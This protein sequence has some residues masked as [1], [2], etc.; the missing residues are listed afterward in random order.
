MRLFTFLVISGLLAAIGV[1][2]RPIARGMPLVDRAAIGAGSFSAIS[3]DDS[4]P[5][6]TGTA[7][8]ALPSATDTI[9]DSNPS[10]NSSLT[11][12]SFPSPTDDIPSFSIFT[13]DPSTIVPSVTDSSV[14][15]SATIPP[16]DTVSATDP[17]ITDPTDANSVDT[18][19]D[20]VTATDSTTATDVSPT[21]S[22]VF[23]VPT[24]PPACLAKANN[25]SL[26]PSST[27]SADP[28]QDTTFLD[29]SSTSS[30]ISTTP[31]DSTLSA[32][33][34]S[35]SATA[36]VAS[37]NSS[38][39]SIASVTDSSA[40]PVATDVTTTQPFVSVNSNNTNTKRIA[41]DDLPAVAQSW[42]DLCLVS[43]G[44]I[45][46]DEPCVIL[47]GIN[48]INALLANADPCDQQ[49]NADAMI[50]FAKSPGVTNS[51]ALIANAIAYRKHPRNALDILD[52]IPS[53]PFCQK[54]PRN[55]E[56]VGIVNDQLPGVDPGIF[57]GP[58][59]GLVAFGDVSSCPLGTSPDVD[60][61][62]CV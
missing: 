48:G 2:A 17:T 57:G 27:L 26:V 10:S 13:D 7:T 58:Q 50:D 35:V 62:G 28:S 31:T 19:N 38:A 39:S 44:D 55:Q 18:N 56:L 43:G 23:V 29:P 11:D 60:T 45:F 41:Q 6:I 42:Q 36:A 46:T 59:F 3:S 25:P 15:A 8:D 54:A 61:C 22:I 14:L 4:T 20:S 5:S 37:D 24:P 21:G 53:T 1:E 12:S 47:A 33:T 49:D 16:T 51:D 9:T 40:L 30:D 52:V 34:D 32:T